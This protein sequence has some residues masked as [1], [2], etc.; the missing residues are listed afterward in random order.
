MAGIIQGHGA[1]T[2][3]L[4][5]YYGEL[6]ATE[7]GENIS[8]DPTGFWRWKAAELTEVVLDESSGYTATGA[9]QDEDL[10]APLRRA[11]EGIAD[12]VQAL[13]KLEAEPS[14]ANLRGLGR[15]M[16]EIK[17][18]VQSL[19]RALILSQDLAH[20]LVAEAEEAVQ[21]GQRLVRATLK[22]IG[23]TLDVSEACE[24]AHTSCPLPERTSGPTGGPPSLYGC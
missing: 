22:K 3:Q 4:D 8:L 7:D 18:N 19:G 9:K 10:L 20:K 16:N 13:D 2:A 24:A 14:E 12:L 6:E 15:G 21:S 5:R 23:A 11:M 17:G 1:L